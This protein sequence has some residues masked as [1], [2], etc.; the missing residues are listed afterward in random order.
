MRRAAIVTT[1]LSLALLCFSPSARAAPDEHI[2]MPLRGKVLSLALYLP[3]PPALR[4][5]G[6]VILG[7]GDVGWV[8]L[9]ASTADFLKDEGYVVV[10]VN[11]RQYLSAFTV[12]KTHLTPSD[13]PSDYAAIVAYL[14]GR[15]LLKAPVIVS[16]VSEGAALAVLGGASPGNREW[17]TGVIT[18]G[19]PPS[20]EL[21]WRWSDF[22]SWVTGKDASEPSFFPRDFIGSVSPVPICMIQSTRDEY[23]SEADYR[24]F[25][26]AA[27]AP[28]K[29]VLIDAA[30]HRFTDRLPELR[31]QLMAAIAWVEAEAKPDPHP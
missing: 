17:I 9:A 29:L 3:G 6:T 19:L 31:S 4:Q 26:A 10:G 15:G 1:A 25:E 8:G 7:S 5:K 12:G 30:N 13:P 21:A 27:R 20:A 28:K 24:R 2:E 18:M 23:V 16:G 22:T 14:R 11:V